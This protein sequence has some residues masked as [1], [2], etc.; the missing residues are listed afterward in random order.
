MH[1]NMATPDVEDLLRHVAAHRKATWTLYPPP[2]G[3]CKDD[4]LKL[5]SF[6]KLRAKEGDLKSVRL[7]AEVENSR[8]ERP[9]STTSRFTLL[10]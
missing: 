2:E 5:T 9:S 7:R 1:I 8:R 10:G 4:S 6:D 3:T